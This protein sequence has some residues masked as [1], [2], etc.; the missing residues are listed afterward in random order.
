[1]SKLAKIVVRFEEREDGGLRA[2]SDD[3]PGFV[4][5][6]SNGELVVADVVPALEG[7][8]SAMYGIEVE[9]DPLESLRDLCV[10]PTRPSLGSTGR[11]IP[12][13]QEYVGKF[14]A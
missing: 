11:E 8:L 9:V 1:M 4:L 2:Y 14:A 7:I 3:V 10:E 5:S 6:H 13:N 12:R